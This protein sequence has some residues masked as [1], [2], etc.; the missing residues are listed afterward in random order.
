M[1][2]VLELQAL[3]LQHLTVAEALIIGLIFDGLFMIFAVQ[4]LISMVKARLGIARFFRLISQE[5]YQLSLE[6]RQR[7]IG[8]KYN[9][10]KVKKQRWV[11]GAYGAFIIIV[12]VS[13]GFS[14]RW[15]SGASVKS[16]QQGTIGPLTA[17]INEIAVKFL[18]GKDIRDMCIG[19]LKGEEVYSGRISSL[20][21]FKEDVRDVQ[22][23]FEG[24]V[25]LQGFNDFEVDD[26]LECFEV[27]E[28]QR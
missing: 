11:L 14:I 23:G 18:K 9:P 8:E 2:T 19:V 6:K 12:V 21:R 20:R 17:R 27:Q 26:I 24:G 15:Q 10:K 4:L 22:T 13:M 25:I 7:S 28:F 16:W 5:T 1:D 3:L